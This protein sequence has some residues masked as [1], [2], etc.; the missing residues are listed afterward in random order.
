M[1]KYLPAEDIDKMFQTI[2]IGITMKPPA[3]KEEDENPE[4]RYFD[5]GLLPI[6]VPAVGGRKTRRRKSSSKKTRKGRKK[7]SK[8][9]TCKRKY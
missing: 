9:R 2:S 8:R 4:S 6:I 5:R 3:S 7:I 1:K